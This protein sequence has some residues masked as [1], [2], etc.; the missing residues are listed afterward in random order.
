MSFLR[1]GS[2]GGGGECGCKSVV[3]QEEIRLMGLDVLFPSR[4]SVPGGGFG[5]V[6]KEPSLKHFAEQGPMQRN[7]ASGLQT[8]IKKAFLQTALGEV[9]RLREPSRAASG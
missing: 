6:T 1:Q 9:D 3:G 2:L 8:L 7:F 4:P 5:C